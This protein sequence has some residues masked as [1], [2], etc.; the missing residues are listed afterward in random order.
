MCFSVH[1]RRCNV[2]SADWL[3][4]FSNN[5]LLCSHIFEPTGTCGNVMTPPHLRCKL[6]Q[7]IEHCWNE[8]DSM[9]I[10]PLKK[11]ILFYGQTDLSSRV[12]WLGHFLKCFSFFL[13]TKMIPLKTLKI[14]QNIWWFFFFLR[15]NFVKKIFSYFEKFLA[16]FSLTLTKNS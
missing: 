12:G 10:R 4:N 3:L 14:S 9:T 6:D 13:V 8:R 11:E 7:C 16:K 5:K 1:V 2:L 15:K